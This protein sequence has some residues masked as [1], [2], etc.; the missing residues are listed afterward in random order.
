MLTG[1]YVIGDAAMPLGTFLRRYLTVGGADYTAHNYCGF[2]P[3]RSYLYCNV[4]AALAAFLVEAASGIRFDD[5]CEER[6]F[7][8]LGMTRA[9]WH[10]AGL[11]ARTSLGRTAGRRAPAT[12]PPASTATPTIRTARSERRRRN[13][14]GTSRW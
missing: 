5:W 13:S 3:G 6:I 4:G 2:G 11:P 12:S 10:L 8:P 9:G 14:P 7:A 1:V